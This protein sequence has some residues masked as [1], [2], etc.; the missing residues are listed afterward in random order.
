MGTVSANKRAYEASVEAHQ[1]VIPGM[2]NVQTAACIELLHTSLCHEDPSLHHHTPREYH[3]GCLPMDPETLVDW[4]DKVIRAIV[5]FIGDA[6]GVSSNKK[7]KA[8]VSIDNTAFMIHLNDGYSTCIFKFY[9]TCMT[10][11]K[12]TTTR[13]GPLIRLCPS[14]IVFQLDTG[15]GGDTI[16]PLTPFDEEYLAIAYKF[17]TMSYEMDNPK[18]PRGFTNDLLMEM[19]NAVCVRMY[20]TMIQSSDGGEGWN[21]SDDLCIPLCRL[22]SGIPIDAASLCCK[23]LGE[24]V[25]MDF[26]HRDEEEGG[27]VEFAS[28]SFNVYVMK[29]GKGVPYLELELLVVGDDE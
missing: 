28:N 22:P 25:N 2:T 5:E 3:G 27:M 6:V 29:N 24:M 21:S 12:R 18:D 8:E 9:R 13:G 16:T 1:L 4:M 23:I 14:W 11:N 26:Y 7:T 20:D 19:S 15:D 10:G 17:P